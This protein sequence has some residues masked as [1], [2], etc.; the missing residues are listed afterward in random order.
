VCE[1]LKRKGVNPLF[2]YFKQTLKKSGIHEIYLR[3][4]AGHAPEIYITGR[5]LPDEEQRQLRS[6]IRKYSRWLAWK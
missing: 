1:E 5:E 2:I 3:V 6:D 4:V